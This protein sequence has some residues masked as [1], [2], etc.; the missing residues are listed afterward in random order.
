M[1]HDLVAATRILA[2]TIA[3]ENQALAGLDLTA[4]ARLL[5]QKEAA[6]AAFT[7]AQKIAKAN[8]TSIDR[9]AL[10]DAAQ[11]LD[12]VTEDNRRLLERAIRVQNRVLGILASA[13][14]TSDPT[15]R[16]GRSGAYAARP[17]SSWAL[18]ASA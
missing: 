2:D 18:T 12:A 9:K 3:I 11:R 7:A 17:T 10:R 13:A 5:P 15:P 16:Y 14:R 1:S 4:A 8:R 6:T